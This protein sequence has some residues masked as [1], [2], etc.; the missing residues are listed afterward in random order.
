MSPYL[1][2]TLPV[3]SV[4]QPLVGYPV[5]LV[6]YLVVFTFAA[7]LMLLIAIGCKNLT[8]KH[9]KAAV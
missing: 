3:V 9:Q 1:P 4:I 8:K 2:C 5:S 6:L 7:Y